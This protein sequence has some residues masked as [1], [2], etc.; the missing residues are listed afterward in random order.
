MHEFS[1][2][3]VIDDLQYNIME[4]E[5]NIMLIGILLKDNVS[6]KS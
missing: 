6:L 5:I 2:N 3:E 4:R 1:L